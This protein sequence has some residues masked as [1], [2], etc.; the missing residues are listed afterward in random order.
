MNL[1]GTRSDRAGVTATRG[2]PRRAVTIALWALQAILVFMFAVSGITKLGGGHGMVHMFAQ[3]GAGQWFRYLIG[4]FELAGAIGVLIPL[5]SGLAALG[6]SG[7]MV[8]ATVTNLFVIHTSPVPPLAFLIVSALVAGGRWPQT[9]AM[10][11][12]LR[13]IAAR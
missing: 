5:L 3:I 11:A 12:N 13:G 4:A 8:G 10:A 2:R 6:L 7:L 1:T 9:R